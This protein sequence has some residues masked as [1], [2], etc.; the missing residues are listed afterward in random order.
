M[1]IKSRRRTFARSIRLGIRW[2]EP[3]LESNGEIG[4][5]FRVTLKDEKNLQ[6]NRNYFIIDADKGGIRFRNSVRSR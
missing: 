3:K 5:Y 6:N 2:E 1:A 4:Y